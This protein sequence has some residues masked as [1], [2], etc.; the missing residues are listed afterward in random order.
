MQGLKMIMET[1]THLQPAFCGSLFPVGSRPE[2]ELHIVY[3][4]FYVEMSVVMCFSAQL[5]KNTYTIL[6]CVC[7]PD[8][9]LLI[10][11]FVLFSSPP[12]MSEVTD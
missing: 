9:D 8:C 4:Y 10:D 3:K 6:S 11:M 7:L 1:V 5:V 2:N 12:L